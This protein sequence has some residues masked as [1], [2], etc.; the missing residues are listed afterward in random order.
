MFRR[1][2]VKTI[3]NISTHTHIRYQ[4]YIKNI[5][6]STLNKVDKHKLTNYVNSLIN[7]S[8]TDDIPTAFRTRLSQPLADQTSDHLSRILQRLRVT[9][10]RGVEV[11]TVGSALN[12][13]ALLGGLR[14][15]RSSGV[16]DA[17]SVPGVDGATGE[18]DI[19]TGDVDV[20]VVLVDP[21][22][23]SKEKVSCGEA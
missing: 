6:N 8:P 18:G 5:R 13:H 16:L 10:G 19:G 20:T 21:L 12:E 17:Q 2:T 7:L 14:Q 11:R 23:L 3:T 4:H 1:V 22:H 15:E 9:V